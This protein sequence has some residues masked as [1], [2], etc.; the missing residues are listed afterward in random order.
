MAG[1]K[2]IVNNP[3]SNLRHELLTGRNSS[4]QH[5][6]EAIYRSTDG[7]DLATIINELIAQDRTVLYD[8]VVV[9][10]DGQREV[11]WDA[12]Q[13]NLTKDVLFVQLAGTDVYEGVELDF[14]KTSPNSITF[15][16]DLKKDYEVFI[17][18]AGTIN[19]ESF[20][21]D[22]F[23]GLTQFR[24]LSDTPKQYYGNGGKAVFV[25]EA[26]TGLV[27]QPITVTREYISIEDEIAVGANTFF[28]K[29]IPFIHNGSIE[30]IKLTPINGLDGSFSLGIWTT[31]EKDEWVYYSGM[32]A[33]VL[34][35]IMR[36]P[37]MD[38]SGQDKVYIRIT[39]TGSEAL[40]K[41]KIMILQ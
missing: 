41:L 30:S 37:H 13:Y 9:A 4:G 7:V 21:D 32:M 6:L 19:S 22:I 17:V 25:N 27:F 40:F 28:E 12:F 33:G 26:E 5:P 38:T 39:N 15:N 20:G 2:L 11:V 24:Q 34:Y 3:G 10:E 35:D 18:L 16:Y 8:R 31:A 36:I 29:W 14:V 1:S 23:N